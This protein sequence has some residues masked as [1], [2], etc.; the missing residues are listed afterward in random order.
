MMLRPVSLVSIGI[1][2][3][4]EETTIRESLLS[5]IGATRAL[6]CPSEIL[7]C[8]N[9][10]TD[11]SKSIVQAL[12]QQHPFRII[13]CAPGKAHAVKALGEA[14]RGDIVVFTDADAIMDASCLSELLVPYCD[15]RVKA[16]T[17]R[18]LPARRKGLVYNVINAR[19]LHPEAEKA[20]VPIAGNAD[21][22]FI[23]GRLFSV[24]KSAF[25]EARLLSRMAESLGDDTF[26]THALMLAYGRGSIALA[27]HA[28]THY[29]PVQSVSSWW[30]K[31][32]RIWHDLD[33]LY[34][35]NPEFRR[36][37]SLMRTRIDWAWVLR[38]KFPV[39]LYFVLERMLNFSGR[40]WYLIVKQFVPM[41][42]VR[43]DDTK[44]VVNAAGMD[45]GPVAD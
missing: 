42:W 9:G 18:P 33:L 34:A 21:K 35:N 26:L 4:N 20:R 19:M 45:R 22:P 27:K 1:P 43:L 39:P 11:R 17:G 16:V 38:Q 3:Y 14:A 6:N 28:H 13:E 23:H 41:R 32:S 29:Q 12:R 10:T 40:A 7:V 30:R 8:F 25:N 24:R 37:R 5:I 2:V 44:V 31:W 15:S 36:L